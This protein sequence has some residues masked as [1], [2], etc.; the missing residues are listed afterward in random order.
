MSDEIFLRDY[1]A[2]DLEA[3]FQ[4]DKACFSEEFRFDRRAMRVFAEEQDAVVRIAETEQ[5]E[6][7]G[8]V[9]VH[10]EAFVTGGRG[11]VVT[12]DVAPDHRRTGMA[13]RLMEDA[14]AS[15]RTVGVQRMELHVY[16]RNE[17]AIRFYEGREYRR[18]GARPGFYGPGLDAWV[19]RKAL[20]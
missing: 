9:I 13:R 12:L 3:M 16:Q 19:Y 8:F 5:G 11:Y 14:E 20:K 15:V 18:V 1:R 10:L 2:P 6:L 4:L 17:E 7:V